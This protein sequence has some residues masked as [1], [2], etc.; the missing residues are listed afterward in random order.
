M[1]ESAEKLA[2]A[3]CTG[4]NVARDMELIKVTLSM[5]AVYPWVTVATQG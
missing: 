5:L 4:G 2:A 1:R 3:V